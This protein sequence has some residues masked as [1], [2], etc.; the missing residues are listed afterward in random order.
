MKEIDVKEL[1]RKLDAKENFK[2][3]DVREDDEHELCRI[4]G[5]ILIPLTEFPSRFADELDPNDEIV[6]HCH[7]GGRSRNA[8]Q[9]LMDSGYTNVA[10][11][12]GGIDQWS[13]QIDAKIK[14]Y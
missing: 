9:F 10:N 8:C 1:K 14:R 13:L 12:A 2:L 6:I 5:A 11:V 4:E 3:V 7:H